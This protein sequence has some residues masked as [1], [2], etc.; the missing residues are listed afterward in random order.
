[1][2][3]ARFTYDGGH[4]PQASADS[5]NQSAEL[6]TDTPR[7]LT[8]SQLR[9]DDVRPGHVISARRVRSGGLV[10]EHVVGEVSVPPATARCRA[11]AA[12]TEE[13]EAAGMVG[14]NARQPRHPPESSDG[15]S[16]D[17]WKSLRRRRAELRGEA[18]A[19]NSALG[20]L[21][22]LDVGGGHFCGVAVSA[23]LTDERTVSSLFRRWARSQASP[24]I[25]CESTWRRQ[26]P[27]V[28]A[29]AQHGCVIRPAADRW[30]QHGCATPPV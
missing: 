15:S 21:R 18:G 2:I 1:M 22:E 14:P 29:G 13:E 12:A 20:R 23:R 9:I 27:H 11:A 17:K 8:P 7:H 16:E 30:A 10:M 5:A 19:L 25:P 3:S 26:P 4:F 28:C 24:R 6:R